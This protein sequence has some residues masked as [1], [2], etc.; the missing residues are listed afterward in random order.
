[1]SLM[2]INGTHRQG[3]YW[4]AELDGK[5]AEGYFIN[6]E[7]CRTPWGAKRALKRMHKEA[8]V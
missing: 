2:D 8:G 1:M 4:V 3:W 5:D 7:F 6:V